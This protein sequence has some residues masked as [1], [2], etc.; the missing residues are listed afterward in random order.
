MRKD[1]TIFKKAKNFAAFPGSL[2]TSSDSGIFAFAEEIKDYGLDKF[3]SEINDEIFETIDSILNNVTPKTEPTVASDFDFDHD[4]TSAIK[5]YP[6]GL[7]VQKFSNPIK[8]NTNDTIKVYNI[9]K[10]LE[11]T[12]YGIYEY[13]MGSILDPSRS[14]LTKLSA[15]FDGDVLIYKTSK[16]TNVVLFY[17]EG[18]LNLN[19]T[20]S[21][22]V[23]YA[24]KS[25]IPTKVSA[26]TNDA[27]YLTSSSLTEYATKTFV[28][29]AVA[30]VMGGDMTTVLS[31]YWSKDE[32]KELTSNEVETMVT[33]IFGNV[34]NPE[35]GEN[36]EG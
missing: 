11:Y 6:E 32:L 22:P 17:Y 4:D 36:P 1:F 27:G 2:T 25:D 8:L 7:S 20:V 18:V 33:D 23:E 35:G 10:S 15:D 5:K 12:K 30:D 26:L 19:Y 28:T 34:I 14:P 31:G 24:L 21:T 3:Q 16:N 9:D 13:S 29:D